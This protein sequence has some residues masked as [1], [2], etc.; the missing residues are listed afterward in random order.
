MPAEDAA[1]PPDRQLFSVSLPCSLFPAASV[2]TWNYIYCLLPLLKLF[3]EG[4]CFNYHDSP[5]SGADMAVNNCMFHEW[6][7]RLIKRLSTLPRSQIHKSGY[8]SWTP[9]NSRAWGL[10]FDCSFYR[11]K[12]PWISSDWSLTFC[13]WR[14]RISKRWYY[15]S[16]SISSFV[17]VTVQASPGWSLIHHEISPLSSWEMGR[18]SCMCLSIIY[19]LIHNPGWSP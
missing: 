19:P 9:Y 11:V 10:F 1:A 6:M 8:S 3:R 16:P 2:N 13:R 14:F 17:D 5:A 12:A 18:K 4:L 15:V 7:K